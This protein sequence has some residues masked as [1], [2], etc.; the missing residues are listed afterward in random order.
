MHSHGS[1][2]FSQRSF[3]H[4][5]G[6][7]VSPA[8]AAVCNCT[9]AQPCPGS[10]PPAPALWS[11]PHRAGPPA[12]R[13]SQCG[14]L[15]A[16]FALEPPPSGGTRTRETHI[17]SKQ[18][19]QLRSV[20][21]RPSLSSRKVPPEP[22]LLTYRFFHSEEQVCQSAEVVAASLHTETENQLWTRLATPTHTNRNAPERNHCRKPINK[23]CSGHLLLFLLSLELTIKPSGAAFF[24]P[25]PLLL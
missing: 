18:R 9:A 20:V 3:S 21:L 7:L 19:G 16:S 1:D 10:G 2:P 8:A 4:L 5:P 22:E 6:L 23:D 25:F 13:S 11:S 15:L 24:F 17:E 12:P 14:E